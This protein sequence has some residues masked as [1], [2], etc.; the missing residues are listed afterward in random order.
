MPTDNPDTPQRQCPVC[1]TW[2]TP[3][4]PSNPNPKRYCTPA[5]RIED[6]RRRRREPTTQKKTHDDEY[7]YSPPPVPG[8]CPDH[9]HCILLRCKRFLCPKTVHQTTTGPGQPRRYCSPACRVA[10]HR[11]NN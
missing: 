11:L 3:N 5:C 8:P 10:Q 7:R 1:W 2:F 9:T 4:S 6:S